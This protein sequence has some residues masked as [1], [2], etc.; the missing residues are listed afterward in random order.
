MEEHSAYWHDGADGRVTKLRC[1][2]LGC[3]RKF[4]SR[5]QYRDHLVSHAAQWAFANG[6]PFSLDRDGRRAGE[7][8]RLKEMNAV[9]EE[10]MMASTYQAGSPVSQEE[11]LVHHREFAHN[12]V[13]GRHG[14]IHHQGAIHRQKPGSYQE[15]VHH[16]EP[17]GRQDPV[18]IQVSVPHP[19]LHESPDQYRDD[20]TMI[21]GDDDGE[22]G[23]KYEHEQDP[24]T[25]EMLRL[26]AV[27]DKERRWILFKLHRRTKNRDTAAYILSHFREIMVE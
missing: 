12:Q 10:A 26:N 21:R 14:A 17:S 6:F 18:Q 2:L 16:R 15:P 8:E 22:D 25:L 4:W 11:R 19:V 27:M 13:P 20:V 9:M 3:K 5:E 24:A 7:S 23:G 1:P